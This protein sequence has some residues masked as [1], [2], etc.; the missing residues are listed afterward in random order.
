VIRASTRVARSL[1]AAIILATV[2]VSGCKKSSDDVV[3]HWRSAPITIDGTFDDW[4]QVPTSHMHEDQAGLKM[5]SDDEFLYIQYVTSDMPWIRTIKMTGLTL[6]VNGDQSKEKNF[7]IR[8]RNGPTVQEL[9]DIREATGDTAGLYM[10]PA[11]RT[12]LMES[13]KADLPELTCF[14]RDWIVEKEVPAD[15]S[16][17]PAAAY[18]KWAGRYAYEF[19]IPL[20]KSAA[21]YYGVGVRPGSK[22]GL[23]AEWGGMPRLVL[24]ETVPGGSE[25]GGERGSGSTLGDFGDPSRVQS[26]PPGGAMLRLPEKVEVW[27]KTQLA[28]SESTSH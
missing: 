8:Y 26:R 5:V 22:I 21:L 18:G 24:D 19:R 17:G 23:G 13:G 11:M 28:S 15:G 9:L 25:F 14:V 1:P 12:Q 16:Q 20:K 7:F 27:F 3:V 10:H 2:A 6:Y 4:N